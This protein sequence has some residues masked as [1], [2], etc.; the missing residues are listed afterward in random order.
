MSD[1]PTMPM[2]RHNP[3]FLLRFDDICPTMNWSVWAGIEKFLA[4]HQLKPILAVVPDNQD[5]KLVVDR[6]AEDF[7]Q[8]VRQWQS[9]GWSIALHGYQH[10][11][12]NSNPGMLK[13]PKKSEFAGLS[14][15][16]Q[17][18]K[19]RAGLA[20]FSKQGVRAD[21]WVAPSHS[22]DETTVQ[23]LA[24]L[25]VGVI[26]DGLSVLPFRERYGVLWVPQQLWE[27]QPRKRGVWTI[28][29][30]HNHWTERDLTNF[31]Q[32]AQSAR[33]HLRSLE[34]VIRVW[35]DREPGLQDRCYALFFLGRERL[36]EY[37]AKRRASTRTSP[38][39][40]DPLTVR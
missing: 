1:A 6:L 28:C 4:E 5:P 15:E 23:L 25:G 39:G 38:K 32:L 31:G 13:F 2:S 19:L 9:W 3:A 14:R 11:Y 18:E 30:H 17:A 20:I 10:R 29:F 36:R 26:S 35:S 27:Y 37:R 8:R 24:E 40:C 21:A 16:E 12:V 33:P 22:F 7:W 34:D